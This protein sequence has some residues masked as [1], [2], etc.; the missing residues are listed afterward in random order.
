MS[1]AFDLSLELETKNINIARYLAIATFTLVIYE[2]FITLDDEATIAIAFAV[3]YKA[4][5]SF[6]EVGIRPYD[7]G[8]VLLLTSK[9]GWVP[10]FTFLTEE[11]ILLL[12]I[13]AKDDD[14][15][16]TPTRRLIIVLVQ[17]GQVYYSC[18]IIVTIVNLLV[19]SVVPNPPPFY[20]SVLEAVLH[21]IVCIRLSAH[22]IKVNE[23]S[24]SFT[25]SSTCVGNSRNSRL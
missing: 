25:L 16:R 21:N 11:I 14:F 3:V 10:F 7:S 13:M 24:A 20:G 18:M 9:L 12:L 1:N 23:T 2:Y 8:C 15:R 5:G 22:L 17:D 4:A 6:V 19:N